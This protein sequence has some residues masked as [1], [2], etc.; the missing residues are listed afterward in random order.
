MTLEFIVVNDKA[1]SMEIVFNAVEQCLDLD[2]LKYHRTSTSERTLQTGKLDDDTAIPQNAVLYV[3]GNLQYKYENVGLAAKLAKERSDLRF[4]IQLDNYH[5]SDIYFLSPDDELFAKERLENQTLDDQIIVTTE[6][7][8]EPTFLSRIIARQPRIDVYLKEITPKIE[9]NH[10]P[11]P[12]TQQQSYHIYIVHNRPEDVLGINDHLTEILEEKDVTYTIHFI[13]ESSLESGLDENDRP[14]P[15]DALLL[16]Q[17]NLLNN[18]P[19]LKRVREL[20]LQEPNLRYVIF[21]DRTSRNNFKDQDDYDM[22]QGFL[23]LGFDPARRI[24]ILPINIMEFIYGKASGNY[25][26]ETDNFEVY[27]KAWQQ[28]RNLE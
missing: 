8:F 9:A 12:I 16:V 22:A 13:H 15:E 28:Q 3:H 11:N 23:E 7:F 10:L 17:G 19:S 25:F 4:V 24:N 2:K 21:I 6:D 20:E 18:Y 26:A 1:R 5:N 27:F 14:F